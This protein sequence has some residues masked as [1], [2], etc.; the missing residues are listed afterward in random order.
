MRTVNSQE[1]SRNFGFWNEQ[2][3]EA[4]LKAHIAIAGVGGDGFQLGLKLAQ[5]GVQHFSIA[6]PECFDPENTNRVPGS[7]QSTYGRNKAEVFKEKVLDINPGADISIWTEGVQ[8]ENVEDFMLDATLVIDESELTHLEIGTLIA[9]QARCQGIPNLNVMNIG[10]AAQATSYHPESNW[11]FERMMGFSDDTP[12]DKV[13]SL[14]MPFNRC[15]PYLP[16]YGDLKTLRSIQQGAPLP[17][18][19]A[20]VDAASAIGSTQ[21]FLHIVKGINNKRPEPIW[22]PRTKFIDAYTFK[23][24]TIRFPALSHY[25]NLSRLILYNLLNIAPGCS[26]T[27]ADIVRRINEEARQSMIGSGMDVL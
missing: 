5:M 6:D 1:Y 9:R 21:A 7:V 8:K 3:Q 20:G 23:G 19:S 14:S 10:F 26:Y 17:S 11:T 16:K 2:E 4:L 24:G 25:L 15:L 12:L 13:K 18:I 22:A 27:E